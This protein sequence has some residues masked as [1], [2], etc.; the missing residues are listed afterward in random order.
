MLMLRKTHD[1]KPTM[2]DQ[3]VI[4]FCKNGYVMLKQIVPD[5]LNQKTMAYLDEHPEGEP[6][7][8]LNEEWFV[9]AVIKNPRVSGVVRSLLGENFKLPVIMSNHRVSCPRQW[10]CGWHRDGGAIDSP[11]LETL[12]VFYYPQD[13]PCVLGPTQLIP[14]THMLHAKRRFMSHYGAVRSAV[15]SEAS[16]GSIFITHYGI[17]HRATTATGTGIRNLLKYNYWRTASPV[18]DWITETE[19]DFTQMDFSPFGGA[20]D[21]H[22]AVQVARQFMW[23]CGY[24]EGFDFKGGQSWPMTAGAGCQST[25]GLPAQ[26]AR[27]AGK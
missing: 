5:Q 16:A 13:T 15:S 6:Q 11:R 17:W 4:D 24:G 19:P 25:E 22:F 12:Q 23:L 18:R 1:C 26:L 2:T 20:L 21:K 14:G 8:I 3:E 7:G 10:P 27:M 9:D